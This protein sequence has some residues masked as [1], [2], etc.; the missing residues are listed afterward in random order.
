MYRIW[1]TTVFI[2]INL[3]MYELILSKADLLIESDIHP[4]LLQFCAHVVSYQ[5]LV[6]RWKNKDFSDHKALVRHPRKALT[7]Y[8]D[9]S[10]IALKEE[11]DKLINRT[12]VNPVVVPLRRRGRP[13]KM[14]NVK[15]G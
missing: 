7:K 8:L 5:A 11:Q 12:K 1:Q 2:P 9:E 3:R 10:F 13:P 4:S 6:K 15:H 14:P